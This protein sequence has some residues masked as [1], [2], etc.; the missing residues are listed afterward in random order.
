MFP[1]RSYKTDL[2]PWPIFHES[3]EPGSAAAP[4][5]AL[6]AALSEGA[7]LGF[8]RRPDTWL[9]RF[10]AATQAA[11]PILG[12]ALDFDE[13]KRACRSPGC[14][15]SPGSAVR[16]IKRGTVRAA[17]NSY[18]ATFAGRG[19]PE[20][21]KEAEG[22]FKL[23]VD[24]DPIADVELERATRDDFWKWRDRLLKGRQPRIGRASAPGSGRGT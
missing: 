18:L 11:I 8:R 12:E 22:R 1:Y 10:P 15:S 16:V 7:Y 6:L 23:T 3:R 9:A 20:A 14:H 4:P 5:R 2:Q 13:A 21:A 24:D 19:E 17:L